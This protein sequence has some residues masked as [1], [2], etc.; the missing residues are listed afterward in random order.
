MM[1]ALLFVFMVASVGVAWFIRINFSRR[2]SG[3]SGFAFQLLFCVICIA[4]Y[5]GIASSEYIA[6]YGY[7]P[8]LHKNYPVVGWGALISSIVHA[9]LFRA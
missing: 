4:F 5:M 2:N 3:F 6:F 9:L 1:P 8:E 7:W